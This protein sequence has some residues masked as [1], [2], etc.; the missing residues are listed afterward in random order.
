MLASGA[1]AG[2]GEAAPA[3]PAPRPPRDR[4]PDRCNGASRLAPRPDAELQ[5]PEAAAGRTSKTPSPSTPRP[6]DASPPRPDSKPDPR[7]ARNGHDIAVAAAAAAMD[8]RDQGEDKRREA[9]YGGAAAPVKEEWFHPPLHMLEPVP[10]QP[11]V[12]KRRRTVLSIA[13]KADLIRRLHSGESQR[14]LALEYG[15]GTS[16][17]SDVKKHEVEILKYVETNGDF[18]A[19]TRR[20]LESGAKADVEEAVFEWLLQEVRCGRELAGTEVMARARAEHQRL[21]GNDDF[22]AST[23]WLER[24]KR[25]YNI[26][27][28]RPGEEDGWRPIVQRAGGD[29]SRAQ[30][31]KRRGRPP[32][33][34]PADKARAAAERL[35]KGRALDLLERV[36]EGASPPPHVK[37]E[38]EAQD[39][40][41]YGDMHDCDDDL[42]P[43][44]QHSLQ[45]LVSLEEGHVALDIPPVEE[46]PSAGEAAALLAK[47]LVWAA[48]QPDTTP[49]E[50]YV[51][52]QLQTKAALSCHARASH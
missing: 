35:C 7:A 13:E 8:S 37:M 26:R 22:R 36:L 3:A 29:D 52:K 51:M 14:Q 2:R 18:V 33:T 38:P 41:D 43:E 44:T 47:A 25:R 10:A 39:E 34:R 48:A 12:P 16:T 9:G 5:G 1:E 27:A 21:R 11:A 6:P 19:M 46:I 28:F 30:R 49:Q 20:K 32:L 50:L 31:G 15:I 45:P 23:G 42:S 4:T 17:V 40:Y 24:F